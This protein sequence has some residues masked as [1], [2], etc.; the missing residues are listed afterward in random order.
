[1]ASDDGFVFT[2]VLDG[3]GGAHVL[4]VDQLSV[5]QAKGLVEW[6]HLDITKEPARRWLAEQQDVPELAVEGMLAPDTEP[7]FAEFDDGIL[8]I[9]R[10]VNTHERAEPDDMISLRLWIG[11]RR[12]IS[13]RLRHLAAIEDI[14]VALAGKSGP[15]SVAQFLCAVGHNMAKEKAHILAG[16]AEELDEID[17]NLA[18]AEESKSLRP[19]IARLRR[20]AIQLHRF[21]KPQRAAFADIAE[22]RPPW[23]DDAAADELAELSAEFGRLAA[24]IEAILGR[25]QVTQDEMRALETQRANDITTTL[26]V[27]A[28]IFLPLG[29]A[30]GL[31]GINVGGI[32]LAESKAGFWAVCGVLAA[33]GVGLWLYFRN[34]RYL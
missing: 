32:P 9:L 22:R 33:L 24:D 18:Q 13:G 27:V 11:P 34:K 15:G 7:R 20:R 23:V 16:V 14:K 31:L 17:E 12:I 30:T 28:A 8:L 29:F 19:R 4:D 5:E 3:E 25:A 10:E 21:F 2:G 1:M 26:T 6:V